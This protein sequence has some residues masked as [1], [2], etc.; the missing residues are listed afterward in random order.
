MSSMT[1]TPLQRKAI[2]PA[3]LSAIPETGIGPYYL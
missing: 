3:S 2:T 1:M